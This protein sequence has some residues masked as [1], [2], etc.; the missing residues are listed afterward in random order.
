MDK[1]VQQ[2][3]VQLT[4][5]LVAETPLIIG[6]DLVNIRSLYIAGA[7]SAQKTLGLDFKLVPTEIE[8]LGVPKEM[9][10]SELWEIHFSNGLTIECAI[11]SV[12]LT[13][14]GYKSV[15]QI[16]CEDKILG[17]RYNQE[18]GIEGAVFYVLES[19]RVYKALQTPLYYFITSTENVL[20][21]HFNE[22]EGGFTFICMRQ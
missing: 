21:P 16:T 22:A 6:M 3:E 19:K 10:S 14:E 8:I 5:G 2:I 18:K 17:A 13:L 9:Y 4:T 12:I 1:N 20:I 15:A 7:A 11:S